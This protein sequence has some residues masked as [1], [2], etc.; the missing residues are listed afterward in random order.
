MDS[1]H[2]E[3]SNTSQV[4]CWANSQ[5]YNAA[6]VSYYN[7]N[8]PSVAEKCSTAQT[9][10][11]ESSLQQQISRIRATIKDGCDRAPKKLNKYGVPQLSAFGSDA[12]ARLVK[13]QG[14][15]D[16]LRQ[17]VSKLEATLL[18]TTERLSALELQVKNQTAAPKNSVTNDVEMKPV[19]PE[20][21]EEDDDDDDVDLFGSDDDEEDAEAV[22]V[23]EERLK[24][25]AE[26]KSKKAGPI[27]KSSVLIDVKPWDDETD[28]KEMEAA[29]R[30]ISMDGLIW[31][32]AG[33]KPLAYGIMKLQILCTI[34]DD[35]VSV[36]D[37]TAQIEEI[38]DLVQSTD[39]AAFNKV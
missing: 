16:L 29:I 27:A 15:C 30:K 22:R 4:Q 28:L 37:L 5:Q 36:D 21:E 35:K 39:I 7:K 11:G 20:P 14:D 25:Y 9:E 12:D 33:T 13:V 10:K 8:G 31:G 34:E 19:K 38:E 6:E 24:A 23:R 2:F 18:E 17:L 3:Y 32:A 1:A 26:K